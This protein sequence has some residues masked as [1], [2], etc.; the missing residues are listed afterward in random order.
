MPLSPPTLAGVIALNL[1]GTGHIGVAVPQFASGV[2]SGILFW[3][4]G[5]L[6]VATV[7]TGQLGT[8]LG[9]IPLIVPQ[10]VLLGF[11]TT[12]FAAQAMLGV[13][14]PLTILGL[15]NGIS[16]GLLPGLVTTTHPVIGAGAGVCT[17]KGAPCT[18]FMIQGFATAGMV[19]LG[20]TKMAA[21][22]GISLDETFNALVLPTPIA[23]PAGPI[24]GGG[25][26]FGQ[27]A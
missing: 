19:G 5:G 2:A 17:F 23:G 26:G 15:A 25:T 24:T 4:T 10:P 21:A 6:K 14:A 11:L 12:N 1:V 22:I 9:A 8:G 7:D 13:F 20:A 16:T 27:I 18:P 3:F